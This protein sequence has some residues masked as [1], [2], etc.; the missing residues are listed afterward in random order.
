V[1]A[2]LA[3]A[4]VLVARSG[5]LASWLRRRFPKL[6]KDEPAAPSE[7]P[8]AMVAAT[9]WSFAGRLAQV[10]QCG[11]ILRAIGAGATARQS[12]VA[13]GI[14][15]VGASVGDLV[16][17]QLGT[18]EGAY[19]LFAGALGLGAA[20]AVSVALLPRF[21]QLTLAAAALAVAALA[22]RGAASRADGETRGRS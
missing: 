8:R 20:A 15:L 9:A 1:C 11:V 5:R 4:V 13:F 21:A 14:H 10:V 2:G 3:T 22:P 16:P 12:A 18:N 17:A 6:A 7:S 19:G